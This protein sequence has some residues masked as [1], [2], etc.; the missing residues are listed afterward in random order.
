MTQI[1]SGICSEGIMVATDSM[2]TTFKADGKERQFTIDKLF[3]IGSHAFI[4]SGGMG[5]SVDLS[6]RFKEYAEQRR[7]VGI[8]KIIAAAGPYLSDQFRQAIG[9]V[10]QVGGMEG[11]LDRIYFLVGGYSFRAQEDPYQLALWGSE[12]GQLP[13]QRIQIA[14]SVAIPRALAGE[15]RL[16]RMCQENR[17]LADLIDFAREFLQKQAETNPQIGPP[18]W[19]G[20]VTPKGFERFEHNYGRLIV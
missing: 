1:L 2:A 6:E 8:E 16:F 13:L 12:E 5:I 18:F 15:T 14:N 9:R 11:R 19:F 3:S 7:L 20:T 10:D 17:S 4:V